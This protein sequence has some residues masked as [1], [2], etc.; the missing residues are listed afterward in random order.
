MGEDWKEE[1]N[2]DN[3]LGMHGEIATTYAELIRKLWSGDCSYTVPR[4][5]KASANRCQ[6]IVCAKA[7]VDLHVAMRG[8]LMYQC[9]LDRIAL[10]FCGSA[11]PWLP[12]LFKSMP[13]SCTWAGG[14]G[15]VPATVLR[16]PAARLPGTDGLPPGWTARGSE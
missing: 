13:H 14:S 16:V 12:T 11:P 15:Q 7:L 6:Q 10:S 1:L 2:L 9:D 4:N 5:F 3:P 8:W